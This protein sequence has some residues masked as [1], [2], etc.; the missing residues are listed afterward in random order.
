MIELYVLVVALAVALGWLALRAPGRWSRLGTLVLVAGLL[1]ANWAAL[2]ELTGR[3][4]PI[5]LE[6]QSVEEAQVLAFEL[7][8]PEQIYLWLRAPQPAADPAPRAYALPWSLE[9]AKGLQQAS[10]AAEANGRPLMMRRPFDGTPDG[11]KQFHSAPQEALPQKQP[12]A[13]TPPPG[14]PTD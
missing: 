12:A 9:Q 8:E 7:H 14:R 3:P 6:A 10:R 2:L 5:W 11:E 4:K 1:F 13:V